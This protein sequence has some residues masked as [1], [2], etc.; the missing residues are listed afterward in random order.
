MEQPMPDTGKVREQNLFEDK[1]R[2]VAEFIQW[3]E[4]LLD[5]F[6]SQIRCLDEKD[7]EYELAKYEISRITKELDRAYIEQHELE[8][9]LNKLEAQPFTS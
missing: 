6:E 7:N 3:L 8:D 4:R 9:K 5:R 1:L 2:G